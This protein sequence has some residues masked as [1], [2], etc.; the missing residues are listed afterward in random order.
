MKKRKKKKYND[1]SKLLKKNIS[2]KE[3]L[4]L[5]YLNKGDYNSAINEYKKLI[6]RNSGDYIF[7]VNLAEIYISLSINNDE[8]LA[9]LQKSI[10]IKP[11]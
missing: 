6:I 8:S 9:L 3:T 4:A 1:F 7:Y 11:N 5:N 10:S 2:N